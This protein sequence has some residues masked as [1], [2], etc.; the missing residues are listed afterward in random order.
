MHNAL[1]YLQLNIEYTKKGSS[2]TADSTYTPILPLPICL[3]G[4]YSSILIA[5][6][7]IEKME[8]QKENKRKRYYE[9]RDHIL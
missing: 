2:T 5:N 6:E 4:Y 1:S 3:Y 7:H 9:P 8:K